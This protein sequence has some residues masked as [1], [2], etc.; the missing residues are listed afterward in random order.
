MEDQ[1]FAVV[2]RQARK[3]LKL[4]LVRDKESNR[5][6]H[7]DQDIEAMKEDLAM[8]MIEVESAQQ[9]NQDL[10]EEVER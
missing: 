2:L 3:P 7:S 8:A 9:E 4:V 10:T 1:E 5:S 6:R